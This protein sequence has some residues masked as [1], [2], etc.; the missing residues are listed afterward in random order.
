MKTSENIIHTYTFGCK[1]NW[2]DTSSIERLLE[3]DGHGKVDDSQSMTPDT[4]VINSCTVTNA[5]DK[6]ARQLIRKVS[7]KHPN[8]KIVVTGCYAQSK[9]QEIKEMPG[10]SHVVAIND[11]YKLP[12]MLGWNEDV[13]EEFLPVYSKRTRANLK[14]QNGCNAYC[15]FCILP[16]IR[17][18][19]TSIALENILEQA[20]FY[21]AQGHHEMV[22]TGTHV[23]GWGRDLNPRRRFSEAVQAI[24]DA[25]PTMNLRISSLEP[26]TLTPDLIKVV[27]NNP[28]IQPHF[29]IPLQS[30]SDSVL[31]RM[32]RK[33]KIKNFRDRIEALFAAQKNVSIGTDV[34]VGYPGETEEEFQQTFDLLSELPINYFHVFP[35]SPRPGT[36]AN[37]LVDDVS[38]DVKKQRVRLLRNLSQKK[39]FAFFGIFQGTQEK[40]V[41]GKGRDENG[42]LRGITPHYIPVHFDGG[43]RLMGCEIE[44][45][46]MDIRK[47][48]Q[49][50]DYMIGRVI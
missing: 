10:V 43:D 48:K 32:N 50:E 39:R 13:K 3:K 5:A 27:R 34:I 46:L 28:R 18:R 41:V 2:Y 36:K 12:Q 21:E 23:G 47:S 40:I 17:G 37:T 11:Q 19:S 15:S 6:Q 30:G 44:V 25:V 45:E 4:V 26:T 33:Y 38:A 20:K 24:L 16:Y 8:A 29:H 14:L 42:M 9:P 31:R 22:L 35:Y 49:D 1:V 7:R